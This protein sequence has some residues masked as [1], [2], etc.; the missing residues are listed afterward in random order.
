MGFVK[1][2]GRSLFPRQKS[3]P[4]TTV[5]TQEATPTPTIDQAAQNAEDEMRL[6]RRRGRN[7][8]IKTNPQTLGQPNVGTKTLTGS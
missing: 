6:R 7:A 3:A 5:V 2:I 1:K 8:Y 4:Q